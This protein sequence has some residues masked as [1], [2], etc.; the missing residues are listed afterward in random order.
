MIYIP[1]GLSFLEEVSQNVELEDAI[2]INYNSAFF[3][4]DFAFE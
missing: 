1:K 3:E 4:N 2:N